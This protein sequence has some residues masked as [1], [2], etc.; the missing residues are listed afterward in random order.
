MIVMLL[1]LAA[2]LATNVILGPRGL[3]WIVWR[4]SANGLNQTYGADAASLVLVAPAALTAAWLWW[5][6]HRLAAPL[7]LG[8]GLATLYYAV[9]E[10]LGSDYI[11]YPG[12]NERFGLLFLALVILS[13]TTAARAWAALAPLPPAP[14]AWLARAFAIVLVLGSALIGCAWLAQL[15]AIARTGTADAAYLDAPS[16]FWTIRIVD[17]GFI[18]PLCL[19]TGV[20]LWRGQATA[21][22]AAYGVAAFMAMQAAAVLAMGGVML[23]RHDPTAS[24]ALVY[25]LTPITLALAAGTVALLHSYAGGAPAATPRQAP[26][27]ARA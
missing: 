20:G 14:P 10:M 5:R 18:V 17:L 13:W 16:A 24:P 4:V 8:V 21:R 11:R 9:A 1:L 7:A 3:G 15:V 25:A 12:N 23:W 22:R 26:A 6:G 2:G 19:A 27:A